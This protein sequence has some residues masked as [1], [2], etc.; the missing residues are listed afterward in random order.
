M[1][2]YDEDM[3]NDFIDES[4]ELLETIEEDFLAL[5]HE[6][7]QDS[8]LVNSLF[9]AVH[10]IK[11][12]A[13]FLGLVNVGKI[14]HAMETLLSNFREGKIKGEKPYIDA[15]LNGGDLLKKMLDNIG[16]SENLNIEEVLN[17]L[18]AHI[19]D[20]EAGKIIEGTS[21]ENDNEN[22]IEDTKDIPNEDIK[23]EN[24]DKDLVNDFIFEA[25][26]YLDNLEKFLN[27]SENNY[28]NI[29]ESDSLSIYNSIKAITGTSK[30]IGLDKIH[31]LAQYIFLEIKKV[32]ETHKFINANIIT[33]LLNAKDQLQ[34]LVDDAF[35]SNRENIEKI[36]N[37]LNE[38]L[39]SKSPEKV[40]S[41]KKT[42]K[43]IKKDNSVSKTVQTSTKKESLRVPVDVIDQLMRLAGELVLIR[44]QELQLL[45]KHQSG[46]REVVQRLDVVTTEIQETIMKT[47]LQ[48]LS[49]IFNKFPR[50][51]RD[52]S[53]NLHKKVN[54]K[55]VGGD[56]E[57]DKT[58]LEE[59]TAPMTHL[60]RN[61][62]DHGVELPEERIAKE[63]SPD[64][65][66]IIS[67]VHQG[68][69]IVITIKDDG[70]GIS[71]ENIKN[72]IISKGLASSHSLDDLSR[73][74]LLNYIF[75]PGFSTNTEVSTVSGR[76][77]GMDVVK[78][79]VEKLNGSIEIDSIEGE[80]TSIVLK[81]PL[82][83][84]I[85]PSL[86]LESKNCTYAIPQVN[87]EILVSISKENFDKTIEKAG[88]E[89]VLRL[90]DTL[91]PIVRLN[92]VLERSHQFLLTD[93]YEILKKYHGEEK[94]KFQSDST[95]VAILSYGNRRYAL[96]VDNIIG[97]EE[98]VVNPMHS[99]V[100]YLDIYSGSAIM[101]DG[102][103]ALILDTQGIANHAKVEFNVNKQAVNSNDYLQSKESVLL[104]Y[105]SDEN[106]QFAIS[107]PLIKRII[108]VNVNDINTMGDK[109]FININNVTLRI[110]R[111]NEVLNV[112]SNGEKEIQFLILFKQIDAPIG[113][114][115]SSLLDIVDATL[116]LA[117]SGY[118]QDGLLGSDFIFNKMT[119]FLDIYQ[120]I[121]TAEPSWFRNKSLKA[122]DLFDKSSKRILIADDSSVFRQMIGKYLTEDGY[123]VKKA[124]DGK[125]ALGYLETEDF[126]MLVSDIEMPI[127]NGYELIY[128][129]RKSTR[130]SNIPA[131]ALSSLN[132]DKAREKAL[133]E[134]FDGYEIKLEE[135]HFIKKVENILFGHGNN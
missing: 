80:G 75:L 9:R 54:L 127:M 85:L 96:I 35:N 20:I 103:V 121:R 125:E 33:R 78:T 93:K 110:L 11:G 22:L 97:A 101:G 124:K 129:L 61:S 135:I 27:N 39:E 46:K 28:E 49:N 24:L 58:I 108:E 38:N 19:K 84:A 2:D 100:N 115:V 42:E 116:D 62:L 86:V 122:N 50:V 73:N 40:L 63:K 89:E 131:L 48:P 31:Q 6:E 72:K 16:E 17:V 79:S 90:D 4:N 60:I 107:L 111:L 21:D 123:E 117:K 59:L 94:E 106:E 95:N 56:V 82:T 102:S 51:V 114:L 119:M 74:E 120:I 70:A 104:F 13:G 52:L 57:L 41:P 44:N 8:E 69:I 87:L 15:L 55:I 1:S 126:D 71:V 118:M 30:F 29:S 25:N 76:G 81:L 105:N 88:T 14:S 68:G 47:R 37:S 83:L 45:E 132:T 10:T 18:L 134:G 91:L 66:L 113:L 98:I 128:N 43:I 36:I 26:K 133:G 77:V 92:E 99:A 109:D 67:A 3:L 23:L 7:S 32:H 34:I 65:E 53:E 130:N 5:E 64:G 12:S 112:S